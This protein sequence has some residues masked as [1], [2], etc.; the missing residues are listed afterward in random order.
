MNKEFINK[1]EA[2][3]EINKRIKEPAFWHEGADWKVGLILACDII[4]ERLTADVTEVVRCKDCQYKSEWTKNGLGE[5]FCKKSGL[6]NL[7]DTCFC[8]CGSIK[9][10]V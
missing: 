7:T 4:N 5:Y 1:E 10:A 9:D 3:Y 8:H 6:W 2:L